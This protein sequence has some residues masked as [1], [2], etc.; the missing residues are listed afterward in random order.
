M[1]QAELR[2]SIDFYE[3]KS[4]GLGGRFLRLVEECYDKILEK[5]K[6]YPVFTGDVRRFGVPR[7]E[8]GIFYRLREDEILVI[9]IFHAK[10][11]PSIIKARKDLLG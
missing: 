6:A 11:N 7:F 10:R 3:S 4:E 8:E 9:A 2:D 1:A 5:P